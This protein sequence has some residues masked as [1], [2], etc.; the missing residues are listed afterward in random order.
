MLA[1]LQGQTRE[2]WQWATGN[3]PADLLIIGSRDIEPAS[4][5]TAR[6]H[7]RLCAASGSRVE[8]GDLELPQPLRPRTLAG[9]LDHASITLDQPSPASPSRAES[10]ERNLSDPDAITQT[11][12]DLL[13]SI[14][15][16]PTTDQEATTIDLDGRALMCIDPSRSRVRLA[17]VADAIKAACRRDARVHAARP[18]DLP[19]T[20]A[21]PLAPVLWSIGLAHDQALVAPI[22]SI[23]SVIARR[24]PDFGRLPHRRE[25]MR[26]TAH[27]SRQPMS[28]DQLT[29]VAE[30][31]APVVI[32]FVNAMLLGGLA[33]ISPANIQ[34]RQEPLIRIRSQPAAPVA[35]SALL[36]R[37][38]A[39]L[40]L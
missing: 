1:L 27:L 15:Q 19:H 35:R 3:E 37:I 31:P 18:D 11:L 25:H 28:T 16:R 21:Q 33:S 4:L 32:G 12:A 9:L 22:R 14:T 29:A 40:G 8:A 10:A 5:S 6:G 13:Y 39:R 7:G 2:L 36:A 30:V 17:S 34:A 20:D 24:W 23:D 26:L 38:R